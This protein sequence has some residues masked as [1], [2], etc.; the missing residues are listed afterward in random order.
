LSRCGKTEQLEALAMGELSLSRAGELEAHTARCAACHHELNWLKSERLM[1]KQRL[2]RATV[3]AL[4]NER[5]ATVTPA[6]A[7]RRWALALAASVLVMLGLSERMR[8]PALPEDGA[9]EISEPPISLEAMSL[10][11]ARGCSELQPGVGFACGPFLP[12]SF[13]SRE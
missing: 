6:P 11:Q 7:H 10:E 5:L 13:A 3:S 8:S 2:S 1:F 9:L 4:W 12:A